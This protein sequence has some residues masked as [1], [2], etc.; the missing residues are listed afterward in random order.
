[1]HHRRRPLSQNRGARA[2]RRGPASRA[3]GW[4]PCRDTPGKPARGALGAG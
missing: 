3:T 1:M 2:T 4:G